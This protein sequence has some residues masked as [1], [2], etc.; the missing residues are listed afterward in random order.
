MNKKDPVDVKVRTVSLRITDQLNHYLD[1]RVLELRA[2]A[3]SKKGLDKSW[4]MLRL[5]ELGQ[6]WLAAFHL[7]Q[8]TD[9]EE[10]MAK[11]VA[12]QQK[13]LRKAEKDKDEAAI[14]Y[15]KGV[16]DG[17]LN[18]HKLFEEYEELVC[19]IGGG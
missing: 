17:M 9:F 6:D 14:Q 15:Q 4:L 7:G 16:V 11:E 10:W 8:P 18:A 3:E 12:A 5:M 2:V 19:K 1:T 13:L